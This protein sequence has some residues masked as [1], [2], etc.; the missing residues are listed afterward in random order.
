MPN[1][2]NRKPLPAKEHLKKAWKLTASQGKG[3][4]REE[5]F[6]RSLQLQISQDHT[7]RKEFFPKRKHGKK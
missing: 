2:R 6:Y 1:S 7:R 3:R 5:Y 4:K